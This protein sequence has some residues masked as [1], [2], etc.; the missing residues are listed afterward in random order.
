MECKFKQNKAKCTCTYESCSRKGI[1]CECIQYHQVS[2]QLPGCLFPKDVEQTYDRSIEK[3]IK[4]Y[5]Q[6]G[7][8]W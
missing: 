1:C 7:A 8:W 3:F 2:G 5:Q 6:R 4:T